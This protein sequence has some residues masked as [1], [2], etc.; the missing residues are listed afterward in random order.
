M[1]RVE[2][3]SLESYFDF[4]PKRKPDLQKLDK[5]LRKSAPD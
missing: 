4:D 2:V 1:F 5:L 3:D